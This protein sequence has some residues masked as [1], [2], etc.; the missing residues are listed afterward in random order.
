MI[1]GLTA[2]K[3]GG[4]PYE[5]A[6]EILKYCETLGIE[7]LV[8]KDIAKDLEWSKTF[9]LGVENIDFLIV[10]GG[11]G[12]LLRTIHKL[13][14]M[15][16]PIVTIKA[17][18]RGFLFDVDPPEVRNR[19]RDLV[20]GRYTIHEYMMLKIAIDGVEQKRI[21]YAVNDVVVAVSRYLGSRVI[22]L[23]VRVDGDILYRFDGDGA[24]VAT[25]LGSS[26]YTFSA[27]GP[28]VD[29]NVEAITI[30]PLAPLQPNARPV[31]LS[32]NRVLDIE[33][34]SESDTATCIVDGDTV[35]ELPPRGRV[36][37]SRAEFRVKF[38]RFKRF[39]TYR[40]VQSCEF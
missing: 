6:K 28:V 39:E 18:R 26:A 3:G 16:I 2:K 5:I 32:A 12:T 33:N 17:G 19:L 25:P 21:P 9:S 30:T 38:V 11:D 29:V 27:G 10:V 23:E 37:I 40:R 35:A 24:I 1:I 22:S 14:S 34:V 4:I 15:R 8:D 7:V 20:E 31:V 36:T 13:G